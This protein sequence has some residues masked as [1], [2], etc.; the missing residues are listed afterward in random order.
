M[1]EEVDLWCSNAFSP[2]VEGPGTPVP[3]GKV[4]MEVNKPGDM[5]LRPCRAIAPN[6]EGT[7][8]DLRGRVMAQN[9][10][11][12]PAYLRHCRGKAAEAGRAS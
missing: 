12:S 8:K 2:T 11:H 1:R 6:A 10:S 3:V 9:S 4:A 5:H 7:P